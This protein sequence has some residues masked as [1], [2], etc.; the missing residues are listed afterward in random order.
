MAVTVKVGAHKIKYI[1]AE[2]ATALPAALA[3]V[4]VGSMLLVYADGWLA[5]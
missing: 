5:G 2:A 1:A 4:V 3:V